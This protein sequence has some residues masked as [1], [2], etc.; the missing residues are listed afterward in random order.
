MGCLLCK[1]NKIEDCDYNPLSI[2]EE[3]SPY[4]ELKL[5]RYFNIWIP[6]ESREERISHIFYRSYPK[7]PP[8]EFYVL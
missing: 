1:N 2:D 3:V 6:F 8:K 5:S 7:P 4:R